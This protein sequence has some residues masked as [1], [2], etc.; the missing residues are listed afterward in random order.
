MGIDGAAYTWVDLHGEGLPGI[1]TEQGGAWYYKRN[2]SPLHG[3]AIVFGP[4]SAVADKPNL[5]LTAREAPLRRHGG[6]RAGS[7][8]CPRRA[9]AGRLRARRRRRELGP[10]PGV[11]DP[12]Q[13]GLPRH[14]PPAGRPRRRRSR[15]RPRERGRHLR[16]A[17]VARGGRLRARPAL[18]A[19]ARRGGRAA[20]GVLQRAGGALPR[21]HVR[22]RPPRPRPRAQR[23]SAATGR[24]S[25]GDSARR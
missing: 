5:E 16:V 19:G 1:L 14:G 4:T 21:G 20:P 15:G 11:H 18:P 24:T 8:S 25:A 12:A 10:V 23:E 7:T 6:R 22:R 2:L 13:P 3:D 9:H 17:P